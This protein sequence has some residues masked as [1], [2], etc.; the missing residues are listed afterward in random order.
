MGTLRDHLRRHLRPTRT[1][2]PTGLDRPPAACDDRETSAPSGAT[3]PRPIYLA[4]IPVTTSLARSADRV[5]APESP[6]DE[7]IEKKTLSILSRPIDAAEEARLR[8]YLDAATAAAT[9]RGYGSDLE[10]FRTWCV[11]IGHSALPAE[12][13]TVARYVAALAADGYKVATLQRRLAAISSAHQAAGLDTPTKSTAVRTVMQGIR[14]THG[15][16]QDG[17]APL[18]PSDLKLMVAEL[19]DSPAGR[20]DRALLLLGFAGAFRRSELVGLDVGDL[21]STPQ[22]LI[23]TLR[24]SKTDQ[25][26]EGAEKGIPKGR[27]RE[28]CP[29]RAVQAWLKAASLESGPLFRAISRSGRVGEKR[30]ADYHVVR[31]IKELTEAI[32][33]DPEDYG[34][35]SLR[36]GLAT[37]AAQAGVDERRIMLQTGHR[38]EKMVRKYIRSAKLFEGNAADGLL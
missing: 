36:V 24:R 3:A 7:R 13:A 25:E 20:R 12:P 31:V 8:A 17:K 30:L 16:A 29:V 6:A 35:H 4:G 11:T 5:T 27:D 10:H 22:G 18:L 34:G 28:L 2:G 32:G 15:T 26:G 9:R 1:T 37:A 23:V 14:R 19:D 38:S 21:R 33:L